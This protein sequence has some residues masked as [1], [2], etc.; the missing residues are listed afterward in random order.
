MR[1]SRPRSSRSRISCAIGRSISLLHPLDR[2]VAVLVRVPVH[3]RNVFGRDFDEP[4]ARFD[5][6]PREQAAAAEAAR[7]V[8]LERRFLFQRQVERLLFLGAQQPMG[9]VERAEHRLLLIV[10]GVVGLRASLRSAS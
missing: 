5:Q 9:R 1:S 6:P 10:A 7:V 8:L 4:R 3:E 2:G